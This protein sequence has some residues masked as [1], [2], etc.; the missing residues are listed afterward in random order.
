MNDILARTTQ[1]EEDRTVLQA[2]LRMERAEKEKDLSFYTDIVSKLR[3]ELTDLRQSKDLE[4]AL[5]EKE[6]KEAQDMNYRSFVESKTRNLEVESKLNDEVH[7]E[8]GL[9]RDSEEQLRKKKLKAYIELLGWVQKY[10]ENMFEKQEELASIEAQYKAE[11]EQLHKLGEHFRRI[12][13][14]R[15]TFGDG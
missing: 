3:A 5:L 6:T 4:T 10:D 11:R 9:H 7:E 8:H 15:A 1:L 2:E 14:D 13:R 12:D